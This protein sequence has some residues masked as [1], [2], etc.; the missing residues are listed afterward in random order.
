M[1]SEQGLKFHKGQEFTKMDDSHVH[2]IIQSY[3]EGEHAY[4]VSYTCSGHWKKITEADLIEFYTMASKREKQFAL[5]HINETS[6]N[7]LDDKDE[8][9]SPTS[10]S[11][12]HQ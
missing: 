11:E 2:C 9:G 12:I 5:N 6:E 1:H 3:V 8:N 7:H 10:P 4:L